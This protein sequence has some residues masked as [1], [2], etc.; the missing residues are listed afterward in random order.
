M[1]YLLAQQ[2]L[3]L[4]QQQARQQQQAIATDAQSKIASAPREDAIA[5]KKAHENEEKKKR[6]YVRPAQKA[7]FTSSILGA[8]SVIIF[9]FS[10]FALVVWEMADAFKTFTKKTLPR[11]FDDVTAEWSKIDQLQIIVGG[12]SLFFVGMVLSVLIVMVAQVQGYLTTA[13]QI[14]FLTEILSFMLPKLH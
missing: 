14:P 7:L 11:G 2:Q 10:S 4:Q 9:L 8:P 12:L 6:L 5:K 13:I 1:E 3:L